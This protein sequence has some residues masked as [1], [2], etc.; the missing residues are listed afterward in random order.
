MPSN[1]IDYLDGTV[2][3]ATNLEQRMNTSN[4][5]AYLDETIRNATDLE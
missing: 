1:W 2:C 3:I 4:W 5:I